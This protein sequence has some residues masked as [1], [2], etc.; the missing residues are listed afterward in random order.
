MPINAT[1]RSKRLFRLRTILMV[2]ILSVLLLPLA[3]LY[4]FR[5]YENE[6]VRKTEIELI[7]QSAAFSAV[8]RELIQHNHPSVEGE[9]NPVTPQLDLSTQTILPRRPATV[10]SLHQSPEYLLAQ[11]AGNLMQNILRNTQEITLAGIRILDQ[12][13]I[14]IAG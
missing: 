8:Y 14:V 11:Q 13:G 10:I 1:P 5:F 3:S 12:N 2:V 4:F 9:Y 7:S 6:L